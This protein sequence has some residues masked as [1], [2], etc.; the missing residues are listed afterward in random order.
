MA[1]GG[2]QLKLTIVETAGFGDQ[3]DKDKRLVVENILLSVFMIELLFF[4]AQ[5]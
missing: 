5:R 2:I 1:E 3:L 4:L